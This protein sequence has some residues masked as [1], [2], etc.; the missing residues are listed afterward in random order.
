VTRPRPSDRFAERLDWLLRSVP[1]RP[2]APE[3]FDPEDL[4]D[5]LAGPAGGAGLVARA[6]AR[7]WLAAMREKDAD[8][9]A[10]LS[11][12]YLAIVED[13]FRLPVGYFRDEAVR[14][15]ADD[16]I[17][18]ARDAAERRVRVIGPC[19]VRG[20]EWSVEELHSLHRQA[21]DQLERRTGA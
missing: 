19:R 11:R 16:R 2:G 15:A 4:V 14:R 5:A 6:D 21:R 20:A 13:M 1:R 10:P 8:V 17:L 12:R 3:R 9:D 18:F 7:A